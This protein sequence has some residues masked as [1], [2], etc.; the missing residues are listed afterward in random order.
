VTLTI[1]AEGV[2][3]HAASERTA[4]AELFEQVG[5]DAPT[6]CTGWTTY[7]L[8]A[9]LVVRERV[10]AAWPGIAVTRL[11]GRTERVQRQFKDEHPYEQCVRMVRQGPP[12][13]L[14]LGAPVVG[15]ALN[16]LEFLVHHEDVRRA[17]P[18]WVPR[19]VPTDFAD[20]VWAQLRL[21][22]RLMLRRAPVGVT[23]RRA[24]TSDE[25]TAKRGEPVVTVS[26]DPVEVALY[27]FNRRGVARV[28]VRG[29]ERARARLAA[30]E[31]GP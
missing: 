29:D 6:L 21:A 17:Q 2:T 23:L 31:I 16:L 4:L 5:P 7:D 13:W 10:P 11:A 20:A 25:I 15:E 24:G 27:A 28:E 3:N 9:H 12:R 14:P 26:G 1:Y 22:S 18:H 8:A 19:A 30:A